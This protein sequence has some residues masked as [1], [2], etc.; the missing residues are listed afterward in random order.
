MG[1]F[2]KTVAGLENI[3]QLKLQELLLL[4]LA[5]S[6]KKQ[7]LNFLQNIAFG[8]PLDIDYIVRKHLFQPLTLEELAKLSGRSLASFKRDFQQQYQSSPK[9]WINDQRLEHARMMLHHSNKQVSEVAMECGF[10]NVPHFIRIFKQKYGTTPN[11][12][13]TKNAII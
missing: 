3:L 13:R 7:V 2:G 1:Y 11:S 4:L 9:K 8:Q 5:G 12:A 10:D 6:H